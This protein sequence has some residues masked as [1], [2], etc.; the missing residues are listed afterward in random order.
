MVLINGSFGT[1][2]VIEL[3]NRMDGRDVEPDP[4]VYEDKPGMQALLCRAVR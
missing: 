4:G 3:K 1:N 2:Y